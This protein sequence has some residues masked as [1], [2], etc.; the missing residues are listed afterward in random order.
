MEE[1]KMSFVQAWWWLQDTN[2]QTLIMGLTLLGS[3][4]VVSWVIQHWK[5]K[6]N[7]DLK[8]HGKAVILGLLSVLSG[9][10]SVADWYLLNNPANF[11][12]WF[13]G[14][15]AG[16]YAVATMLHRVHVSPLYDKFTGLLRH[17]VNRTEATRQAKYGTPPAAAPASSLTFED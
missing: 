7:I 1:I 11:E 5:R 9:V 8:K 3:S 4:A 17:I 12:P 15:G 14:Y 6:Y 16:I 13:F 10:M 2:E